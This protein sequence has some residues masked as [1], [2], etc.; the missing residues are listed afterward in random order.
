M[1]RPVLVFP[2]YGNSGPSHWQSLWEA[3]YPNFHRVAQRDWEHP[4][5]AEWVSTLETAV[6]DAG[7]EAIIVA[8]SLACL[9]VAHWAT[10]HHTPIRAALLVAP[11]DPKGR[12]F[13][14]QAIG[15]GPVPTPR[16]AF[17]STVVASSD[18]PYGSTAHAAALASAWG[19]R[20]VDIGPHGHINADSKLG[21]WPQGFAL[22]QPYL[23]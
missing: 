2:G 11:P 9:A 15:F 12:E 8:H 21:D 16:F 5:C 4:V 7:P 10:G 18:D 1:P 3:A 23:D 13:P 17:P 22:L 20:F 14:A 6:R 19:S